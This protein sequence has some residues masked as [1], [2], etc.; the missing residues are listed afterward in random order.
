MTDDDELP[1]EYQPSE[2]RPSAPVRE[3]TTY[4]VGT[5]DQ[6][7]GMFAGP[8]PDLHSA[9]EFVP[10]PSEYGRHRPAIWRF[11]RSGRDE[12]IYVWKKD[13]WVRETTR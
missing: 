1:D 12:V 13:R 9:L 8:W 7:Y 3:V 10:S 4:A 5:M 6:G 11:A 2:L